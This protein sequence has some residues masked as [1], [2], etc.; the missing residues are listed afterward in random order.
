MNPNR[1]AVLVTLVL[2]S[3][4]GG[5]QVKAHAQGQYSKP[6]SV[7]VP[8]EWGKYRGTSTGSGMVFED[9]NG[10]LRVVSELPCSIEGG[11][12]NTPRVLVEIRRK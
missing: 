7:V 12:F 2:V 3:A 4:V 8:S 6:C 10:T 5:Y 11:Y 9:K 1:I